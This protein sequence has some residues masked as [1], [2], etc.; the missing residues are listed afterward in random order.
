MSFTIE[1]YQN[2]SPNE[3]IGKSLTALGTYTGELRDAS[4]VLTPVILLE[5]SGTLYN[6]NYLKISEFGRYYYI[7]E[8]DKLRNGLVEIS[9]RC[10][11]LE[12]YKAQILSHKAVIERQEKKWNLYL[13][14]GTFKAYNN[15][16]LITKA[17]PSGFS[18][19]SFLLVVAG[20]QA[21]GA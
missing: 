10:D 3:K 8:I 12:T 19:M 13:D 2:A 1:L 16:L 17:F 11:A 14:D 5:D 6:A 18:G 7:T 15:P 20:D 4:S 9:A 21:Q